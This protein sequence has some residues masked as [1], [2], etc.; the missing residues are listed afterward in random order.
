MKLTGKKTT[1]HGRSKVARYKHRLICAAAL[2]IIF[3]AVPLYGTDY[4]PPFTAYLSRLSPHPDN[5]FA[6]ALLL[7]QESV[8]FTV[9][10]DRRYSAVYSYLFTVA[11]GSQP[12]SY[13]MGLYW[14]YPGWPNSI[15]DT[16]MKILV[17]GRPVRWTRNMDT[18]FLKYTGHV[19]EIWAGIAEFSIDS[20]L[21]VAE[22]EIQIEIRH[23]G[24]YDGE[25][26]L[27]ITYA[28][29][30]GSFTAASPA[31][32]I[33]LY[34]NG[35]GPSNWLRD[36]LVSYNPRTGFIRRESISAVQAWQTGKPGFT[37]ARKGQDGIQLHIGEPWHTE[38][39]TPG[40]ALIFSYGVASPAGPEAGFPYIAPEDNHYGTAGVYLSIH[41][42][43]MNN[44]SER[45]LDAREL[46]LLSRSQLGL[47]RNAFYARQGYPFRNPELRRYFSDRM[48]YYSPWNPYSKT[49][50]SYVYTD[51][52]AWNENLLTAEERF[53]VEL[54]RQLE[55][56]Q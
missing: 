44:I 25:Y 20:T 15:I 40:F 43:D 55:G 2:L 56:E 51:N 13:P 21:I 1:K 30:L 5:T 29:G 3:A 22:G 36:V 6:E 10:T 37:A 28:S 47:L 27:F 7:K 38:S 8:R 17:N 45:R 4:R 49:T 18:R 9:D 41:P 53:N 31:Q 32:G 35:L 16:E 24:G 48:P 11:P 26:G 14:Q 52:P 23:T 12:Q 19:E 33:S 42:D 54:I 46:S 39:G 34:I 50:G